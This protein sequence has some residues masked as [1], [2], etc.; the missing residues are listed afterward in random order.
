M[1]SIRSN[2]L[3]LL[4]AMLAGGL[5]SVIFGKELCY[6][7]ANY[8]YYG[9]YAYLHDRAKLDFWPNSYVL[10]YI[11][12]TIDFLTYF[13][14]NNFSSLVVTFLLGAI[15]GIN[16]WLLFLIA[17]LFLHGNLKIPLAIV[18]A[19]LGMYGPTAWPGIGSFQNDNLITIFILG[20]VFL[21][22]I[23]L[24][25]YSVTSIFRKNLIIFSGLLLGIG[26]GLKLTAGIFSVGVLLATLILPISLTD[27]IK[28][29]CLISI[30]AA[31]GM[32]LISG[33]WMLLMWQQ[34][35][36]PFFPFFNN[37]FH[38]PDFSNINWRDKR[39]LPKNMWETLFYPYFFSW[40]GRIAD[41]PFRD[42]RFPIVYT[43]FVVV[44]IK[45]VWE[46]IQARYS[47]RRPVNLREYWLYAFF[48]F[49]YVFWQYYFSISRYIAT[50]EMLAPLVIFLLLR[51][52]C[53]NPYAMS[54]ILTTI[55]YTLFFFMAPIHMV[56]MRWYNDSFFNIKFPASIKHQTQAM[57]LMSFTS[58]VYDL[59]PR[60]QIY[61]IP[62]F[63]PKWRFVGIPF[64]HEKYDLDKNTADKIQLLIHGYRDKIYL[65]TTDLNMPEL[66]RAAIKF[67][68]IPDGSCERISSDRQ[69]MTPYHVLLCPVK[70]ASNVKMQFQHAHEKTSE[71]KLNS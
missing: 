12:P 54:I 61:L 23:Q 14:I 64:L 27:R 36:N 20:F 63:P 40:D 71:H 18:L 65:L 55:F 60:P 22:L 70:L 37:I 35:H 16:F 45:Y 2:V 44:G 25:Y 67:N 43:L 47:Q 66:Y 48:I 26:I 8:H 7:L 62:F 33:Y 68:L 42:F 38:S 9:P 69:K 39:F 15:H 51:Q 46:K 21:Q 6:D 4:L 50:L 30:S 10:Q 34:H 31:L 58:Y 28:L 32:L 57:V 3:P 41:A 29:I 19:T 1:I 52:I 17:R 5:L 59:D 49:S 13:L 56:R 11:S 24:Q 53:K